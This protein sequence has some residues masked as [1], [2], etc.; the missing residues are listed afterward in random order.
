MAK[1]P[2]KKKTPAKTLELDIEDKI[3][4]IDYMSIA[5]TDYHIN[6]NGTL[7]GNQASLTLAAVDDF[8]ARHIDQNTLL[9]NAFPKEDQD[10]SLTV[11]DVALH[12]VKSTADNLTAALLSPDQDEREFAEQLYT[13]FEQQKLKEHTKPAENVVAITRDV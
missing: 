3:E 6:I 7:L 1:K 9:I 4:F 2:V 11:Y 13:L 8:F 10:E 12:L 5:T